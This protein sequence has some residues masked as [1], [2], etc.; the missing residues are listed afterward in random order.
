MKEEEKVTVVKRSEKDSVVEN[1]DL[2]ELVEGSSLFESNGVS[3]VKVTHEGK[4]KQLSIPIRSTGVSE[5]MDEFKRKAPTPPAIDRLAK[6]DDEIGK[7]LRLREKRWVKIFDLTDEQYLAAQEKY[8]TELGLKIVLQGINVPIK[9]KDKNVID[10]PDRKIEI[11]KKM[12]IS[13]EQFS[14]LVRDIG[15]LTRW[16][17]ERESDFLEG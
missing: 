6:P 15:N 9:D 16:A 2:V 4:V 12:G 5:I 17:E 10:D 7:S 13:G 11:L 14:Q 1:I 3:I 8:E